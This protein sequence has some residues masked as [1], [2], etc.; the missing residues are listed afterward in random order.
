MN[1]DTVEDALTRQAGLLGVSGVSS[2]MRT[3]LKSADEG[4][5]R[6]RLAIDIFVARVRAGIA[7]MAAALGGLDGLVFAGGIGE[8]AT[9]IRAAIC[10][11]LGFMGVQLDP[12]RNDAAH[13]DAEISGA[14]SALRVLVIH[15][16]E[17]RR[18]ARE[19]MRVLDA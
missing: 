7:A 14:G 17:D 10:A 1:V 2:D 8:H 3:L 4:N 15:T 16:Q 9:T 13:S 18:I 11:P 5:A 12:P 19:T 6:A